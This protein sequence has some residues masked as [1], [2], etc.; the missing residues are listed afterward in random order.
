MAN[1]FLNSKI[2]S[3]FLSSFVFLALFGGF[4]IVFPEN[5][6]NFICLG[7]A[8]GSMGLGFR[9]FLQHVHEMKKILV[10]LQDWK[11]G[12]IEERFVKFQEGE[13]LL[14]DIKWELNGCMDGIDALLRELKGSMT[15]IQKGEYY[16]KILTMGLIG[17]YKE[18]ATQVNEAVLFSQVKHEKVVNA[19]NELENNIKGL[20]TDLISLIEASHSQSL[21]LVG[22]AQK[23]LV[24]TNN[25]HVKSSSSSSIMEALSQ[26]TNELSQAILEISNRLSESNQMNL[27]AASKTD[28]V[29]QNVENLKASSLKIN[30][31]V[32]LISSIA[33]QTNLLALNA[34]IEAARAGEEGK[35]FAVVASEVKNLANQ[36]VAATEQITSQIALI[37]EYIDTTVDSVKVVIDSILK[38]QS[39][40]TSVSAAVEEQRVITNNL[41]ENML[42]GANEIIETRDNIDELS[43]IVNTTHSSS[44]TVKTN[45]QTVLQRIE[46]LSTQVT[47]FGQYLH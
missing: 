4:L 16:R 13:S 26:A 22:V 19:G 24:N 20:V 30:E 45:M 10:V 12:N 35:S 27:D 18:T 9:Y 40:S 43:K 7:G 32:S 8:L 28:I 17:T 29:S 6:I 47:S 1:L 25:A 44:E 5:K 23:A 31:V 3:A 36:T 41:N 39:I 42:R 11:K 37:K 46:Y 14:S 33:T 34:T 15:A 21:D 38:M 2:L